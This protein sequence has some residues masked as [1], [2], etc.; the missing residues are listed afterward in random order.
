[1]LRTSHIKIVGVLCFRETGWLFHVKKRALGDL[2]GSPSQLGFGILALS[3]E[4][5]LPGRARLGT[6]RSLALAGEID[7]ESVVG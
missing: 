2:G 6:L 4:P 7:T 5:P 3:P 1:M